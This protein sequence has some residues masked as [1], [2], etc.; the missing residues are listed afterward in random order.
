LATGALNVTQFNLYW[1][2]YMAEITGKDAILVSGS[3]YLK[4]MDIYN[5]NFSK[6]I[7]L[8]GV[9]FRLNK[10]TDYNASA[11]GD[12]VCELINPSC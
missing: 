4:P 9:L 11:P 8:D 3:F 12:C 5:L 7:Q 6:Y 2:S 10:I 1:S